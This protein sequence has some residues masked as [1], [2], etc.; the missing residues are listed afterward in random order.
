MGTSELSGKPRDNTN[1]MGNLGMDWHPIQG[2]VVILLVAS[3]HGNQDKY[4][5]DGPLGSSTD[6]SNI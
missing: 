1:T 5:L 2:G 4:R 3:S 6:L